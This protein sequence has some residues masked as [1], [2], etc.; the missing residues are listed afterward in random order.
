MFPVFVPRQLGELAATLAR[1][2]TRRSKDEVQSAITKITRPRWV[3][4]VITTN[5][6]GQTPAE[7]RLASKSTN[8]RGRSWRQNS[9]ANASWSPTT[10]TGPSPR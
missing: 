2:K 7:F 10:T 3:D 5:L 4:R 6:T 1:G 8:K 9:S